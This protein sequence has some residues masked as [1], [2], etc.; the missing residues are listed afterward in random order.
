MPLKCIRALPS[1]MAE[2]HS[3]YGDIVMTAPGEL[4]SIPVHPCG[5]KDNP[6]C[7]CRRVFVGISTSQPTT[8]ARVHSESEDNLTRESHANPMIKSSNSTTNNDMGI[9]LFGLNELAYALRDFEIGSLLRIN[10]TEDA[11]YL[12]DTWKTE[13]RKLDNSTVP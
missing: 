7:Q 10:R 5:E 4:L 2:E 1:A 3:Q 8:L 9:L 12:V 6:H 11:I 13:M